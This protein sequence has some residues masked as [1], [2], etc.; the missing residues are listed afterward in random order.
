MNKFG[1]IFLKKQDII[2]AFL[3]TFVITGW[4]FLFNGYKFAVSDE[5]GWIVYLNK[6]IDPSL[7]QNDYLWSGQN[8]PHEQLSIFADIDLF[9]SSFFS[10]NFPL[11]HFLLLFLIKFLLFVSIYYLSITIFKNKAAAILTCLIFVPGYFFLGPLIGL[12]E[13]VF[14]PRVVVQPL[15]IFAIALIFNSRWLTATLLMGLAFSIHAVSV[16]PILPLLLL[17]FNRKDQNQWYKKILSLAF[18]FLIGVSPLIFKVMVS[19]SSGSLLEFGQMSD[20]LREVVIARKGYLL[21]SIWNEKMWIDTFFAFALGICF[22]LYAAKKQIGFKRQIFFVY[23]AVVFANILYFLA[24]DILR[25]TAF[26]PLQFARSVNYIFAINHILFGGILIYLLQKKYLISSLVGLT[27]IVSLF[28]ENKLAFYLLVALFPIVPYFEKPWKSLSII[29]FFAKPIVI[30]AIGSLFFTIH[31]FFQIK[32]DYSF[33]KIYGVSKNKLLWREF[34]YNHIHFSFPR[35]DISAQ[36]QLWVLENTP[37]EAVILVDPDL[38]F[39]RVYSQRAVVFDHKD[40]GYVYYS[41]NISRIIQ[42]IEADVADFEDLNE[43][44]LKLLQDKYKFDYLVW[45]EKRGVLNYPVVYRQFG[46]VIYKTS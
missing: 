32:T 33:E 17:A 27:I 1:N 26:L 34:L 3:S 42:G 31:T 35:G 28:L 23:L 20:Y 25:F 2:L 29:S 44:K 18:A 39:F 8:A 6:K 19:K 38:G 14:I 16:L 9:F 30:L 15:I 4:Y 13:N 22:F 21:F 40:L 37:K 43:E 12:N 7:Y 24:T 45:K 36:L 11:T 46:F 5:G 10:Y 41:D